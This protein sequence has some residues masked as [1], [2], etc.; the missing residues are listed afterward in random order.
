MYGGVDDARKLE[1]ITESFD[2]LKN[3]AEHGQFQYDDMIIGY[4]MPPH[5]KSGERKIEDTGG[6]KVMTSPG[7]GGIAY[8]FISDMAVSIGQPLPEQLSTGVNDSKNWIYYHLPFT[9]QTQTMDMQALT[10][11]CHIIRASWMLNFAEYKET[12]QFKREE[13]AIDEVAK[14]SIQTY[15]PR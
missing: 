15:F 10:R 14:Q 4:P 7:I 5:V 9:Q 11:V 2:L 1:I 12:D 8:Q 13:K 6:L 3:A